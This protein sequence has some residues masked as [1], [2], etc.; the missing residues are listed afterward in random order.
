MLKNTTETYGIISK[1]FH[2]ILSICYVTILSIG[3][4]MANM[5]KSETKYMIYGYHKAFGTILLGLGL[6]R[7][8]WKLM[9]ISPSYIGQY[10]SWDRIAAKVG[11]WM[12]YFFVILMP[13]SAFIGSLVGG[14]DINV[15]SLFE[16]KAMDTK[17]ESLS[18]FAYEV[19]HIVAFVLVGLVMLHILAAL[20]HH[21]YLKDQTLVRMLPA[22]KGKK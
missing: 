20:Y 9:N 10:N 11:H 7:L 8:L 19:H 16:I 1:S 17:H 22:C 21:F 2:W 15:F 5:P 13:L 6:L 12:L 14:R 18:K 4:V 3:F